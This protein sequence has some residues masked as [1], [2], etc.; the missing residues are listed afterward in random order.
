MGMPNQSGKTSGESLDE[1]LCAPTQTAQQYVVQEGVPRRIVKPNQ[2][3]KMPVASENVIC[4]PILST[5][6][7]LFLV[8]PDCH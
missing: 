1:K 6:K 8:F 3:H 2:N 5:E 4:G 7:R